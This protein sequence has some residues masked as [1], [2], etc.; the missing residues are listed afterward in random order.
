MITFLLHEDAPFERAWL[1]LAQADALIGRGHRVRI[2]TDGEQVSW[3][4][5]RAEWIL[6]EKLKQYSASEGEA[7]L[8]AP[9]AIPVVDDDF[10]RTKTPPE[11]E[12]MRVLLAGAA[13]DDDDSV[14]TGYGAVAHARWFHQKFDLIRVSQ[15]APS[16][17]EPLDSVQEFHVA[18]NAHEMTRL[19]HTCDAILSPHH[20]FSLTTAQALASGVPAIVTTDGG[21]FALTAPQDNPVEL[22]ERLIELLGDFELRDRLRSH[23][24]AHAEQWRAATAAASLEQLV[25]AFSNS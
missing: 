3:R 14:E 16:R 24:R 12:P 10:F 23:G 19:V 11:N 20:A 6:V 9:L 22:G 17:E 13:Q 4:P 15:W 2:V 8:T 21:D 18:L 7:V 1:M 25:K 5:S